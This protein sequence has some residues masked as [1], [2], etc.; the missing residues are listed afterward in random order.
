M[1]WIG[2]L[3]SLLV[4]VAFSVN[5]VAKPLATVFGGGITF[6]GMMMALGVREG[7]I[8][9]SI[10][11]IGFVDR[12]AARRVAAAER[13]IEQDEE[14]AILS[15]GQ[16]VELR[17]L[18]PSSTLVAIRGRATSLIREA[19]ARVRGNGQSALYCIFVDEMPGLFLSGEPPDPNPDAEPTLR[20]ASVEAK[21]HG[22]ELIPIWMVS[23][24][25]ADGIARAAEA[26]DVDG[27]IVGVSRR[28]ALYKL[29]RGQVVKGLARR[30][31]KDCHLILCN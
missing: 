20:A 17:P 1:F 31:P 3:T 24:S 6:L 10:Y 21:R 7:W 5:L 19:A 28:N 25:A 23:F 4:I 9:E 27:V 2:V 30:L 22:V 15:L 13:D 16:A 29:L 14:H 18:F 26:L 8:A 12:L 11:S